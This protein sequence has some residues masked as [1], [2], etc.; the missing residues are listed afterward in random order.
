MNQM[1]IIVDTYGAMRSEADVIFR[2]QNKEH[3]CV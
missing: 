2:F 3:N 1:I